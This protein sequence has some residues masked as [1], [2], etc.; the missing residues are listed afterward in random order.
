M[1]RVKYICLLAI[2]GCAQVVP[3]TAKVEKRNLSLG[4][5]DFIKEDY[6]GSDDIYCDGAIIKHNREESLLIVHIPLSFQK[7][8][9]I[10]E[11]LGAKHIVHKIEYTI[12]PDSFKSEKL[13]VEP[14]KVVLKGCLERS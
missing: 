13:R 6:V 12:E 5:I 4:G 7:N 10:C 8:R 11:F 9:L 14:G 1:K 3:K 2:L